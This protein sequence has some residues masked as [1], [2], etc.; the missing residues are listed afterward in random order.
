MKQKILPFV[1]VSLMIILLGVVCYLIYTQV[2]EHY[3]QDEPKLNELREIFSKF[4]KQDKYW[5]PP[6]DMLNKRNIMDD[7]ILYRGNK[8]YT[9]NKRDTFLCL[10]DENGNY[11][12]DNTLIFVLAHEIAHSLCSE[13]GHTELFHTIFEALLIELTADGIYNPS[14]PVNSEYCVNGDPEV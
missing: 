2:K 3:T 8:S 10:K 6:L 4:F 5:S 12:H 9:I 11:F 14:I 13:I 1:Q 7:I